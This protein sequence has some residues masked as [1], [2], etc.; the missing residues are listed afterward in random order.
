MGIL[1]KEKNIIFELLRTPLIKWEF[2]VIPETKQDLEELI[3]R[4]NQISIPFDTFNLI[5]FDYYEELLK[6]NENLLGSKRSGCPFAGFIKK[7]TPNGQFPDIN[8]LDRKVLELKIKKAFIA[9]KKAIKL[10]TASMKNIDNKLDGV[11]AKIKEYTELLKKLKQSKNPGPERDSILKK[12]HAILQATINQFNEKG[13]VLFTVSEQLNQV[14]WLPSLR[15]D[16]R[17]LQTNVEDMIDA[18]EYLPEEIGNLLPLPF[19]V[20]GPKIYL[21]NKV[22]LNRLCIRLN[23]IHEGV[24]NYQLSGLNSLWIQSLESFTQKNTH[25]CA[26]FD[27]DDGISGI[28]KKTI[29]YF[30]ALLESERYIEQSD[31]VVIKEMQ[32]YLNLFTE[33]TIG[34]RSTEMRSDY[35]YREQLLEPFQDRIGQQSNDDSRKM[36]QKVKKKSSIVSK[37]H[38]DIHAHVTNLREKLKDETS[39]A[40]FIVDK[41]ENFRLLLKERNYE[42]LED[43]MHKRIENIRKELENGKK[44]LEN[45]WFQNSL[46]AF[47]VQIYNCLKT[48]DTGST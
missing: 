19:N 20:D 24:Q 47:I 26:A 36:G 38:F 16:I 2:Q 3:R 48:V 30:N 45:S 43:E 14:E 18:H 5:E 21:V 25:L 9:T 22:R 31:K 12:M 35:I 28:T 29:T 27:Q 40:K 39:R 34:L 33:F 32:D 1:L 8:K 10:I 15:R 17:I 4:L 7:E 37:Q 46:N 41:I 23:G 42:E 11:R 44:N 13:W 6:H